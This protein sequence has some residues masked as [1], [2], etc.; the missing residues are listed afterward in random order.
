MLRIVDKLLC[1]LGKHKQSNFIPIGDS[2]D[3]RCICF[4]CKRVWLIRDNT[5]YEIDDPDDPLAYLVR[6][7]EAINSLLGKRKIPGKKEIAEE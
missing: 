1:K 5:V 2:G 3:V 4:R 6:Q 7:N